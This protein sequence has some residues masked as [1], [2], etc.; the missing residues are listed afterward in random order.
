MIPQS[1]PGVAMYTVPVV[2]GLITTVAWLLPMPDTLHVPVMGD[3]AEA[4]ATKRRRE[5]MSK[6]MLRRIIINRLSFL[7]ASHILS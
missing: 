6:V 3:A 2:S 7:R 4:Q 5:I 1:I